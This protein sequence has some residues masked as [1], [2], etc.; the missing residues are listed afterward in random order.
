MVLKF[1]RRIL[2]HLDCDV[3]QGQ[4]LKIEPVTAIAGNEHRSDDDFSRWINPHLVPREIGR[5]RIGIPAHFGFRNEP[6]ET[7]DLFFDASHIGLRQS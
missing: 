7:N 3:A 4:R 1:P 5:D 6:A 2:L